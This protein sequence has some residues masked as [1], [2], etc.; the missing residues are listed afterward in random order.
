M[1]FD[2][3]ALDLTPAPPSRPELEVMTRVLRLPTR[4]VRQARAIVRLQ[5]DRLSPLPAADTVFDLAPLRSD[6]GETVYALGVLR[7]S[8]LADPALS[9]QRTVVVTKT[10]E[11][12]AVAFRFRN[13]GVIDDREARW[14]KHAP[15]L[16]LVC[17][18]LAAVALAGQ[19]RA[20]QWR[21]RR[22]PEIAAAQRLE[23]RQVRLSGQRAAAR[24]EWASL[25][26]TDAAT[27]YL[28]AAGRIAAVR[29][30]GV[31]VTGVIAD[32]RRVT[33][34]LA[35]GTEVA[36]LIDALGLPAPAAGSAGPAAVVF[37]SEV[38]A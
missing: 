20:E 35:P 22:L 33:L 16:A 3:L 34:A 21:D 30:G 17:L 19:L 24:A 32:P 26:R 7:R 2:D 11:G 27:R 38:C 25:E 36:P 8:A 6:A 5:L 9:D 15:K 1:P 28:C 13:P 14:L 31:A 37:P 4:S 29:P 10:V 12:Q 23:T 18:G